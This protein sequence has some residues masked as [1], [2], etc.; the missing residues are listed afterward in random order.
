MQTIAEIKTAEANLERT[1]TKLQSLQFVRLL[2]ADELTALETAQKELDIIEKQ[3]RL[4]ELRKEIQAERI[5]TGELLELQSLKAHI[6]PSDVELLQWAGVPETDE[7]E[8]TDLFETPELIPDNVRAVLDSY[9]EPTYETLGLMLDECEELGYTFD[10][11]LDA[12]PYDLRKIE[13]N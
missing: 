2:S 8:T 3:I 12:V 7:D 5:S 9:L 11:Y 6:E 4:E 1:V 10:Y 13:T